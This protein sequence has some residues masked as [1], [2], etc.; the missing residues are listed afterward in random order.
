MRTFNHVVKFNT[1]VVVYLLYVLAMLLLFWHF[2]L[3]VFT[4]SVDDWG[5]R[6]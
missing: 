3:A 6:A 2:F 4:M 1:V 5:H